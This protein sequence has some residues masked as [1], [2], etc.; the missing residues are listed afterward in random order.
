ME[1]TPINRTSSAQAFPPFILS[2]WELAP[3][4]RVAVERPLRGA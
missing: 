1:F 3:E 2:A 4:P